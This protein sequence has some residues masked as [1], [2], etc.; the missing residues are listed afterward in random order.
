MAL[1]NLDDRAFFDRF[2]RRDGNQR[3]INAVLHAGQRLPFFQNTFDKL[4]MDFI[5]AQMAPPA[6]SMLRVYFVN[7]R[8]LLVC[9]TFPLEN[10][11]A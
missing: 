7:E 2:F 8:F 6:F 11:D 4:L 5:E 3:A 1:L 9:A 10:F